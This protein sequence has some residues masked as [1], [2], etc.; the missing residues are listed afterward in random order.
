[1]K[2]KLGVIIVIIVL[3][4]LGG[5][6]VY[7]MKRQSAPAP[8]TQQAANPTGSTAPNGTIGTLK[9]LLT[10]AIPQA[11]TFST[12]GQNTS[13]GTIYVNGGKMRGDFTSTSQGQS[14]NGHMILDSG[15]SYIWTDM[16]KT[17][18]KVAMPEGNTTT[19]S[20]QGFD[21]NQQVTYSCK[22]WIPDATKFTLPSDIT[23]RTLTIP[24]AAAPTGSSNSGAGTA[25]SACSAC[26][27]LPAAAQEV[28]KTQL[29]CQ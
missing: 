17:G 14:I 20:T 15:Y 7:M 13:N 11:C 21:V 28:C 19:P 12:Q 3:L 25:T 24:N 16:M 29:H 27:S 22:P 6:G 10:S 26:D 1:M 9:G 8:T 23:F 5:G 2:N 4:L 18:M